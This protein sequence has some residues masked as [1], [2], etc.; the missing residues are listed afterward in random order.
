ME[1][2]N[3]RK[4]FTLIEL[5]A[6]L[7]V[8][9]AI[10]SF[11]MPRVIPVRQRAYADAVANDLRNLVQAQELLF[12]RESRFAS[13]ITDPSL[14]MTM[15]EKVNIQIQYVMADNSW[16]ATGEYIGS[17][18]GICAVAMGDFVPVGYVG[19]RV[20]CITTW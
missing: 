16:L 10:T 1:R 20:E 19:S 13:S 7:T 12:A 14:G 4:G 5:L 6:A 9:I 11:V 8:I 3:A 17:P 15:S 2:R 18:D